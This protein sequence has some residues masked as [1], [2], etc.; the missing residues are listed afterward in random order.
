[1][2]DG[3]DGV[4]ESE[5]IAREDILEEYDVIVVGAGAAGIGVGIALAHVGVEDFLV[6]DRDKVGSSFASWPDETRFITPCLLYTSPS[7]RD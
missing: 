1:M 5:D 3:R 4:G 6:V 2:Q 7:P